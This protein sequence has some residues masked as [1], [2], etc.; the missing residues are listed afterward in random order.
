[1]ESM[2]HSGNQVRRA[3]LSTAPALPLQFLIADIPLLRVTKILQLKE[4]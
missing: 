1:M 2:K 4:K 3:L